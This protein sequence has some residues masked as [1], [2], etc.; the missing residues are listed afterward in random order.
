MLRMVN[1]E[2]WDLTA[3]PDAARQERLLSP[4]SAESL[5]AGL[6]D[7]ARVAAPRGEISLRWQQACHKPGYFRA[8]AQ[9]PVTKYA[10]DALFNGRS[11]YRAQYYLSPEEGLLYNRQII[12]GLIPAV[13]TAYQHT[14]LQIT[15][16]MIERSLRTPHAKIWVFENAAEGKHP[17]CE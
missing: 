5:L 12:D 16:A 7:E 8:E 6:I 1:V 2:E 3:L 9:I 11:G 10:Y 4:P 13:H 15:F 14:P 17:F